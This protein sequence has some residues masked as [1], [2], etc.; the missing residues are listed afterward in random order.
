MISNNYFLCRCLKNVNVFLSTLLTTFFCFNTKK[1]KTKT[2]VSNIN[3][4][5]KIIHASLAL[6]NVQNFYSL[7]V[8]RFICVLYILYYINI[9]L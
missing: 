7:V 3:V 2:K 6:H 9:C 1:K 4:Q 8:L 5:N